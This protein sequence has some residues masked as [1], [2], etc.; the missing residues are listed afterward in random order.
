MSPTIA[1]ILGVTS[2]RYL[3]SSVRE[4]EVGLYVGWLSA[5]LDALFRT[6][7]HPIGFLHG[8]FEVDCGDHGGRPFGGKNAI[9]CEGCGGVFVCV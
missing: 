6:K 7:L 4:G 8:S 1:S 9:D 3:V 5:V 2:K